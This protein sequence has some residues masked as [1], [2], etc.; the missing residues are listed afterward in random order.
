M[1]E[2]TA[3]NCLDYLHTR[4]WIAPGPAHVEP[5]GWGVSNAVL[6]VVTSERTFI[7]KQS[8]PQLRTRDA[9]F[10]DLNRVYREQEVMEVLHP[11]LPE[12]TVPRVLFSDRDNYVFAMSH[13]PP[14]SRVWK[15]TLLSG[16]VDQ[17]VG[18]RAGRILG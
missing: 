7:L 13:A 3:D 4:G 16:D 8:R 10:S 14:S 1:L 9:W 6:R 15:E 17:A 18:Q 12:P 5:L 11:L 2:L